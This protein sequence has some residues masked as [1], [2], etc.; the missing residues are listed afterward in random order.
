[1]VSESEKRVYS[2]AENVYLEC[3]TNT[4]CVNKCTWELPDGKTCT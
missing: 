1:M 2:G 3:D 4:N